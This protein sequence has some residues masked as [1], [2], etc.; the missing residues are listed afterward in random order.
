M[1]DRGEAWWDLGLAGVVAA[2]LVTLFWRLA[3]L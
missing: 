3:G 1:R 2:L